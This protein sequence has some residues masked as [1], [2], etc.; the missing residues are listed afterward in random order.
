MTVNEEIND[1]CEDFMVQ[2]HTIYHPILSNLIGTENKILLSLCPACL[3][4]NMPQSSIYGKCFHCGYDINKEVAKSLR[5]L[6]GKRGINYGQM[7]C[8]ENKEN[9]RTK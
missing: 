4:F 2:G 7:D 6:Y 5:K 1:I 3:T 8:R 9:N